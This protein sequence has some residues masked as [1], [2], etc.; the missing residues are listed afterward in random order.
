[1]LETFF[2]VDSIVING[3]RVRRFSVLSA[4]QPPTLPK[5]WWLLLCFSQHLYYMDLSTHI[6]ALHKEPKSRKTG[7]PTT[8]ECTNSKPGRETECRTTKDS[9]LSSI[10]LYWN[11]ASENEGEFPPLAEAQALGTPITVPI[12]FFFFYDEMRVEL[13]GYWTF[14]SIRMFYGI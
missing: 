12:F 9:Q 6:S 8:D 2:P 11:G 3:T 7:L 5:P 4:A 14:L 13:C 1:M 10:G